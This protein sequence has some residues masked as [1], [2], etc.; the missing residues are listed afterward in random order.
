MLDL[1]QLRLLLH[2]LWLNCF[3]IFI[4]LQIIDKSI[5]IMLKLFH[6]AGFPG[7]KVY[8]NFQK[9]IFVAKEILGTLYIS[10]KYIDL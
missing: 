4:S 5:L 3:Y 7:K 6:A 1:A 8:P 10:A 2:F 9:P